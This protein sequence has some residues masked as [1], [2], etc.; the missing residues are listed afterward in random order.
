MQ[1]YDCGE[2]EPP[3]AAL[4]TCQCERVCGRDQTR[5]QRRKR[6]RGWKGQRTWLGKGQKK[7]GRDICRNRDTAEMQDDYVEVVKK[8]MGDVATE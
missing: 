7:A 8:E 3:Y 2:H 5:G 4:W 6:K 1:Q